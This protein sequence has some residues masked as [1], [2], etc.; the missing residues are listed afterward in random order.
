MIKD[1][2]NFEEYMKNLENVGFQSTNLGLAKRLLEENVRDRKTTVF[3]SFT[4]NLVA[5]GLRGLIAALVNKGYVDVIITAGGSIDHDIAKAL[6]N[7]EVGSFDADDYQLHQ[8]GI[9]RLG[10]ILV[11]NE[12]YIELEKV[13]RA[14]IKDRVYTPSELIKEFGLWLKENK[15]DKNSF[16]VAAVER[17]VPIFS[18][19]IIDA[20]IG[21]NI[22]FLKQ[23]YKN[24]AV[25]VAG[26]LKKLGDIVLNAE[27]TF[28]LVL[29][30]GISKHHTIAA[31]IIRDGLDAAVYVTTAVEWDGSLSGARTRE[32]VSWGK[33]SEKA[34]HVTVIGEA[35]MVLPL[36]VK[37]LL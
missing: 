28:A 17:N 30:G 11:P 5:S 27:R 37:D 13:C 25:D 33:I 4:S 12:A 23:K 3:L 31:N 19:G 29:G 1:I 32:A 8:R 26:D 34:K 10:N 24:L 9:N 15:P 36:L 7:Y 21:L 35:T 2:S 18:P 14:V 6:V 16:L 20:A 22:Y